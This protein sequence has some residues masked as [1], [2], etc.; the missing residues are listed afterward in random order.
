MSNTIKIGI[1]GAAQIAQRSVIPE[2]LENENFELVGI[3][4]KTFG[5]SLEMQ[6]RF[7]C[8]FFPYYEQLFDIN[9]DA[10][11]IPLPN[12]EH[13][14]W[15]DHAV[16]RGINVLVEK[17]MVTSLDDAIYLNNKASEAGV[18]LMENFQF[19]FHSQLKYIQDLIQDDVIGDIRLI[20]SHFGF[21]PFADKNNIRYFKKLGGG[22]LFDAGA[23]PVKLTQLL[24]GQEVSVKASRLNYQKEFDVDIWGSAQIEHDASG[25]TSQIGFGFDHAYQ[26]S[27]EVWGTKGTLS[28]NRIFTAR[29]DHA[30]EIEVTANNDKQFIKLS[31][32]N[33]FRN[34]LVHFYKQI[35]CECSK[36]YTDNINQA[37]LIEEIRLG[38]N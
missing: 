16:E 37:R 6:N 24:L 32:D 34:M 33:H 35:A 21:P 31:P 5:N 26:N 8:E 1:L 23:Y 19:R 18:V 14:E 13:F 2:I 10:I 38:S 30:P 9:L 27:L 22:A 3:A 17:S 4:S 28:T 20:K 25:V 29:P 12:S 11:Y 36:E 15:I 7:N